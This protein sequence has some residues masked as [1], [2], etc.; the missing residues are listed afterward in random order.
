MTEIVQII[1]AEIARCGPVPFRRFMELALY[2]TDYGYYAGGR[3]AIGRSGDYVTSV[4][5][6][7]LFGR[8]LTGQFEEMWRNLDRPSEFTI[9]EQGAHTGDFARD[10]L[11]A[12]R[13]SPEFAAALRYVVVEPFPV[14]Q[15]RQRERLADLPGA[16][17]QWRGSLAEVGPFTGV[18]FSNELLDAMP[19]HVVVRRN[20]EWLERYVAD[21]P[22]GYDPGAPFRWAEG[23]LSTPRLGP[24][25]EQFPP[26]EGYCTEVNLGALDWVK[27]LAGVLT[28]GYVLAS[29][30]GFCQADYYAPE[31]IEGTLSCYRGQTRSADALANAGEQDLTAHVEFTSVARA[32]LRSGL[33]LAGFTDQHHFMIALGRH[34]FPD[35]SSPTPERQR[36]LRAFATLMH[37]ALMGRGFQFMALA[38]AAPLALR[39]F[40]FASDAHKALG[41]PRQGWR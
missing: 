24:V 14:N 3:A 18:H 5:T 4:S 9:V 37:P 17:V 21:A 28:R 20:G 39:G 16:K 38:K 1:R 25:V 7:P 11:N 35:D 19:V 40:E 8:L 31:R 13:E 33:E 26:V 41:L 36:E 2:E 23:P 27:E 22:D 29:D 10:V 34:A 32:A 15:R 6:G 12:A 30:Y